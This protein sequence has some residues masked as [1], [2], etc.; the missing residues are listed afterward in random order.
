MY[1]YVAPMSNIEHAI[2]REWLLVRIEPSNRRCH[3]GCRR[4]LREILVPHPL[5]EL[6]EIC[7]VAEGVY[8]RTQTIL[9]DLIC[10]RDV[11]PGMRDEC[12]CRYEY[13]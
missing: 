11:R 12:T 4:S 6:D 7:V 10:F 13:A 2:T 1:I 9:R 3:L 5:H 8:V